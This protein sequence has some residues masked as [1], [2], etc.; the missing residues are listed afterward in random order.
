[1]TIIKK[2]KIVTLQTRGNMIIIELSLLDSM[3]SRVL[4]SPKIPRLE[5][6]VVEEPETEEER[7][8]MRIARG[9]LKE[10][11]KYTPS[12]LPNTP[13]PLARSLSI[14]VSGEEY[15]K[16]GKPTVNECLIIKLEYEK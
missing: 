7:I 3:S 4:D 14:E 16:L 15:E 10:L 5:D 13:S 8:A 6:I 1:M 12:S 11:Q 9:Y 2:A